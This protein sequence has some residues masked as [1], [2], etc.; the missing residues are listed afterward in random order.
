MFFDKKDKDARMTD[1]QYKDLTSGMSK[2]E[3]KKRNERSK[4]IEDA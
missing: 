3:R 1:K 2:K 4:R